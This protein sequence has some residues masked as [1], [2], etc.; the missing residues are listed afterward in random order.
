MQQ[1]RSI[2]LAAFPTSNL[3]PLTAAELAGITERYPELPEHLRQL[4]TVVG[5]GSIGNSR[6]MIHALL[7]PDELYDPET[8]AALA[9]VV[10]V[11]DDFAG[12]CEAYDTKRG[13]KFGSIGAAGKF[14]ENG[15]GDFIDF[16]N[17]WYGEPSAG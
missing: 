5:I 17:S 11:G 9:G 4:F 1:L 15:Y 2:I 14:D 12:T 13:W 8:A 16:L 7:D 3:R 10:V 6:Y